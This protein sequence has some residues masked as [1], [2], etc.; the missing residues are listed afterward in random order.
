M[1]DKLREY[2]SNYHDVKSA[3]INTRITI[4]KTGVFKG[5]TLRINGSNNWKAKVNKQYE[6]TIREPY[7]EPIKLPCLI[8]QELERV[9]DTIGSAWVRLLRDLY[10]GNL[11]DDA[12]DHWNLA[13]I[14]SEVEED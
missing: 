11:P 3:K 9:R 6:M 1:Y 13:S 7:A 14:L 8:Q 10:N 4:G 2:L 12:P 5:I